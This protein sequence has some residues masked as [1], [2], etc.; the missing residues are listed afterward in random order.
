MLSYAILLSGIAQLVVSGIAISNSSAFGAAWY[1]GLSCIFSGAQ[2]IRI[3]PKQELSRRFVKWIFASALFSSGMGSVDM[4]GF[5]D[6]TG[7]ACSIF[8]I[9]NCLR[10]HELLF[11]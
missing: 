10:R 11:I 6:L 8:S 9:W 2:G 4:L 7:C 1:T 3:G 5:V